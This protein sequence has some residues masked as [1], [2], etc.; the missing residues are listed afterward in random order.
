MV[1]YYNNYANL[2]L[3]PCFVDTNLAKSLLRPLY[4]IAQFF[5]LCKGKKIL[6]ILI[7]NNDKHKTSFLSECF[8]H[9]VK[10]TRP[11]IHIHEKMK[12]SISSHTGT[13]RNPIQHMWTSVVLSCSDITILGCTSR[14]VAFHPLL[15]HSAN[16]T[17]WTSRQKSF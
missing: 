7:N 17:V 3:S 8:R 11:F 4:C 16:Q 2:F 10:F 12:I 6:R 13:N 9:G 1:Y 5:F 15:D 14:N